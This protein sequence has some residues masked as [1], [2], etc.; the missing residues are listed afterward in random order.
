MNVNQWVKEKT[1]R[2]E[3]RKEGRTTEMCGQTDTS[4]EGSRDKSG[5]CK[6]TVRKQ[7][8]ESRK[9]QRQAEVW[10]LL[11]VDKGPA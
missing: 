5:T 1:E 2:N 11:F 6:M 7:Q 9:Q 8:K 3:T 10:R 4:L